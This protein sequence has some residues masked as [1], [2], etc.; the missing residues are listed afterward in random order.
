MSFPPPRRP[1]PWREDPP[2]AQPVDLFR[3]AQ[4]DAI[5][6]HL[7]TRW[8]RGEASWEQTLLAVIAHLEGRC[9]RLESA[10][11]REPTPPPGGGILASIARTLR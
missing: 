4:H 5:V 9:Q 1:S 3:L 6:A 11:R 8:K 2:Q 7:L 10:A